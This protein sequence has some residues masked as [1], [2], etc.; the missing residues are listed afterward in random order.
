[1]PLSMLIRGGTVLDVEAGALRP[2]DIALDGVRI[3]AILTPGAP[4]PDAVAPE[5]RL[6]DATGLFLSPGL[7]DA[8]LHTESSLLTP[9]EFARAALP[10]GTTAAFIDPHEM[11]N[12]FGVRALDY[13][14]D[15]A[16]R[17]PL[18][19]FVGV[20]SCVPATD[21]EEAGAE[22]DLA[23]VRHLLGHS[24]VYGLAEMMNVP[25]IIH[26]FGT[27]R[28]KVDAALQVGKLVDGHCPGLGGRSL[29]AYISNGR[30]D[31]VA[32]IT[33]DHEV[34]TAAEALEKVRAGMTV[35]LRQGS[36]THDLDRLLP[37]LV[38]GS[39]SLDSGFMLC[40][41]DLDAA[42]LVRAGH[43]NRL[44]RRC[45]EILRQA[46]MPAPAAAVKALRL[47]T[48][49][50]ATH[51]AAFFASTGRGRRGCLAPD[52]LADIVA[53]SDLQHFEA[54][55]VV[56]N[57]RLAAS[58]G[59][60]DSAISEPD[61]N[62]FCQSV[63]LA[64]PADAA[65]LDAQAGF[66]EGFVKVRVIDIVPDSLLT[67]ESI[68]E[69]R[70][71]HGVIHPDPTR[72]ILPLAVL[73]R[74]RGTGHIGIGFVRGLGLQDGAL[75]STVTHDSHNLIVAGV[76]TAFMAEAANRLATLGGGM[77]ALSD[78]RR[79]ELPLPIAGLMACAP[80]TTVATAKE[81]LLQGARQLGSPLRNPFMTLSFLALP[82][83]PDLKLTTRGLFAVHAFRP[84]PLIVS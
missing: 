5:T 24:Q 68:V 65:D 70:V 63:H 22:I 18:D 54:A 67:R 49:A 23:Q 19:L 31:G 78:S 7:I 53:F 81:A 75:A 14:L 43:V 80:A 47:A 37:D 38:Q 50:P 69:L 15:S 42:E 16:A 74:H 2:A 45:A 76:S 8:H 82:V 27:G 59:R 83:I 1:M 40:S 28:A 61:V 57:G 58:H 66:Q 17:L 60:L 73:E 84:V 6:L 79:W 11:A 77:I 44:V 55:W 52:C 29:Q 9:A 12:V 21:I 35:A 20:P 3:A 13:V 25:G 10:H 41:D 30:L 39:A 26:G 32:R 51:Y 33:S 72:D 56:K 46:G 34:I 64:H 48:L 36:A 71:K 62:L 4:P